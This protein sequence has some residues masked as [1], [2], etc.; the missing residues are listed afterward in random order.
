MTVL[1]V[2]ARTLPG[3]VLPYPFFIDDHTFL[4][5]R[6]DFWKGKPHSLVGFTRQD[7]PDRVMV[8]ACEFSELPQTVIG[9]V[10]V[11]ADAQGRLSTWAH[12]VIKSVTVVEEEPGGEA[13][14][15]GGPLAAPE[16]GQL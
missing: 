5:G 15:G 9:M 13:G 6:Q 2:Q 10:P 8:G 4:V 16:R 12:L 14:A 7:T 1:K 11:F 3:G